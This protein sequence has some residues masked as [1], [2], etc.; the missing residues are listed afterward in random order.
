M[1]KVN[2][3]QPSILSESI[4]IPLSISPRVAG[5]AME[6][7]HPDAAAA[8]SNQEEG[9][10]LTAIEA[11]RATAVLQG[12]VKKLALL[13]TLAST[14]TLANLSSSSSSSRSPRV[15]VGSGIDRSFKFCPSFQFQSDGGPASTGSI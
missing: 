11:Q 4:S 9:P 6:I 2:T 5:G 15:H 1:F 14:P 3:W 10:K 8:G 7:A 13:G 12:M